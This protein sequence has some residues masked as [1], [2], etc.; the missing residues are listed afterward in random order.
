MRNNAQLMGVS[1][2]RDLRHAWEQLRGWA[3]GRQFVRVMECVRCETQRVETLNKRGEFVKKP[4]Y[5]Y[6]KAYKI[7]GGPLTPEERAWIRV[8][9][10]A[11]QREDKK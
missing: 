3:E 4:T 7:P 9:S 2:C 10:I 1:E 6:P 8:L 5:R 11:T